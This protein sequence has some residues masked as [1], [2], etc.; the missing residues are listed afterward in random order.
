MKRKLHKSKFLYALFVLPFIYFAIFH[1]APMIGNIMAFQ[2]YSII[3]GYFDSPWAGI[4][5][6]KQFLTDPYFWKV[7]RNTLLLNFYSLIFY[8]PAPIIFAILLNEL[9]SNKF[10]RFIQ[11]VTYVPHFLS[12]VVIAGIIIN[13]LSI[14]GLVNQLL[15][16]LGL[17]PRTFMAF[18]EWFRTIFVSSEIWQGIG[19]NSIIYLAAL[20][21]IDPGL[22]EAATIDGANRWHKIRHVTLPGIST[23][24]TILLLLS[25]GHMLS[26]GFEKIILLYSGPTYETADVIQTYVYRRGLIDA[27]FSFAAAVGIF[28]S[29]ISLVLIVFANQFA[30]RFNGT[31]L[32]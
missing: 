20:S 30:K 16:L 21:S 2:E 25:I 13:F 23:V 10:K 3:K 19:W 12:T 5:Y 31:G 4:K 27:D 17:E 29:V 11:T 1:Y 26:V 22:Y 9:R 15:V 32:F 28:Q 6:F 8:F 14:S 7:V 18:P 24:I